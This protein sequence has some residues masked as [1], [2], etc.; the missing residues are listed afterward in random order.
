MKIL[1]SDFDGTL[2]HGGFDDTKRN[3]IHEWRK[4]GNRFGIVSGRGAW[5][6]PFFFEK[7]PGLE[8]DFFVACNGAIVL[9]ENR[10]VISETQCTTVDARQFAADLLKWGAHRVHVNGV[11]SGEKVYL[12]AVRSLADLPSKKSDPAEPQLIKD[13]PSVDGF[14]QVSCVTDDDTAAE[15]MVA[16]IREAY[17]KHLNPLQNGKHIDV[18][19]AGVNKATG[20]HRVAEHFGARPEDVIAVG[21]NV[22][23]TDMIREFRSY[24]MENGVPAIKSLANAITPSV[25]DLLLLEME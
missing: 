20:L 15:R 21:D 10:R 8:L 11:T 16:R 7:C 4:K 12:C 13:L 22:N 6:Y 3:T 5:C 19:P 2:S 24:A 18:V 17:G 9:D 14:F 25:T 1:G 23:D